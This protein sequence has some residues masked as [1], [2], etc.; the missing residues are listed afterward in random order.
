MRFLHTADWHIGKKL[1]GHS[2]IEEQRDALEQIQKLA[3]D[4][5]VDA[6]VVAGDVYDRSLPNE[7]AVRLVDEMTE[8]INLNTR[9][10][11]LMISGNHDSAPRLATGAKWFKQADFYLYT[12]LSEAFEPVEFQDTQFFLLPY[13]ELQEARN[14]FPGENITS[15]P[16]AMQLVVSKMQEKFDPA[17]KHVLVAH[18]FVAGS[19]RTQSETKFEVGGLN[20]VPLDIFDSFDHVAL[21]HLH[22]KNALKSPKI[23]Y[24]GSLLKY[25]ISESNSQKGAWLVD[26]KTYEYKW[27][28]LKPLHDIVTLTGSFSD[29]T[30]RPADVDDFYA[31]TVTDETEI[32]DMV[33]TLRKYYPKL[34]TVERKQREQKEEAIK[35]LN[36]K[37]QTPAELLTDFFEYITGKKMTKAQQKWAKE[38]LDVLKKAGEDK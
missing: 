5:D 35:Q 15:L 32:I 27:L 4:N 22:D 14:N 7:T 21:G 18:F 26:T 31:L 13:F 25:S 6:I 38:G 10:P 9:L 34:L 24:S 37:D 30:K 19:L 8:K 17:K 16:Q 29:L 28:E 36:V 1:H 23:K 33:S 11:L 20:A 2:L 3:L 12:K